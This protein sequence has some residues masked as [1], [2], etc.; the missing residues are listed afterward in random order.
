MKFLAIVTGIDSASLTYSCVW[1]KCP[2]SDRFDATMQ[3]SATDPKKKRERCKK[4]MKFQ[5]YQRQKGSLMYRI[6][7]LYHTLHNLLLKREEAIDKVK[8]FS[9]SF[10]V[11]RIYFISVGI[12]SFR[13]YV[14]KSS[15][16]LK[17]QTLT[18]PARLKVIAS[19]D[20]PVLFP[21]KPISETQKMQAL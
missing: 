13:F 8:K 20:V 3:W 16:Q 17:C 4:T 15:L 7:K 18:G 11:D 6:G 1:C 2:A 19:I 14:R 12:P 9:S 21:K 5:P 10:S